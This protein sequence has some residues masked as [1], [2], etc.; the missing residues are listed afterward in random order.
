MNQQLGTAFLQVFLFYSVSCFEN[1]RVISNPVSPCAAIN[2][3]GV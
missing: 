1:V 3:P 2:R